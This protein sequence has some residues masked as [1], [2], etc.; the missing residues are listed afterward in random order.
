MTDSE[1]GGEAC[2]V[3]REV[4]LETSPCPIDAVMCTDQL[5]DGTTYVSWSGS[6]K[7]L[8]ITNYRF[9]WRVAAAQTALD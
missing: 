1:M 8:S 6:K 4:V 9:V 3:N 7:Q 5:D 2:W